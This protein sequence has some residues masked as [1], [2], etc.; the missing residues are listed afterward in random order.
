MM[1][2]KAFVFALTLAPVT[3]FAAGCGAE[4]PATT[5]PTTAAPAACA[6]GSFNS[7]DGNEPCTP[8]PPGFF[9]DTAGALQATPCAVGTFQDLPGQSSCVRAAIGFY[10][11]TIAAAA[12]TA[13][14]ASTTTTGLGS[15]SL[16]DCVPLETPL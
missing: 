12:A 3:L 8:A 4:P 11:D 6:P 14:P 9:V 10:V 15:D 13:C 7:T 5:T 2:R 1:F 16:D